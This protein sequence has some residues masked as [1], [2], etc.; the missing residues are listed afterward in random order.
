MNVDYLN[1]CLVWSVLG[2][3]LGVVIG[4]VLRLLHERTDIL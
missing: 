2:L 3:L 4:Y 1:E